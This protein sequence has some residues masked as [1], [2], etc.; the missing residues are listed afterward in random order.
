M[1]SVWDY[2]VT[3]WPYGDRLFFTTVFCLG[4]SV[5]TLPY[6]FVMLVLHLWPSS[7]V[8]QW[9]IQHDSHPST[10]LVKEVIAKIL[11]GH[12]V[13]SPLVAYFVLFP[14]SQALEMP[15]RGDLPSVGRVLLDFVVFALVND[16]L[17]Y[18]AHRTL[19]SH[20]WLYKNIHAQHHRFT[21]PISWA[22]EFSHPIEDVFAGTIPTLA[23]CFLMRSH[24]YTCALWMIIRMWETLD[25]HSGYDFPFSPWRLLSP[26]M[27]GPDG[28]DWHHS[29]NRGNYGVF[30][31]WDWI[32]GT[33]KEYKK[34]LAGANVPLEAPELKTNT[35]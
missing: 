14:L 27:L 25:A 12:F 34:W 23:G 7:F 16:V 22:A 30:R 15:L 35:D 9:K 17:F 29:H 10:R 5:L 31:F 19:H 18:W 26:L 4:H 32:L 28:H 11:V 2:A 3:A 33:D 20:P 13:F 6:N 8:N 21:T 1:Q 24:L